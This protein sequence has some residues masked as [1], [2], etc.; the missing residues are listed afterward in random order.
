MFFLILN[1]I[2]AR[3]RSNFYLYADYICVIEV[4]N[5]AFVSNDIKMYA[6]Q[7]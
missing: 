2:S 7:D 6:V 4:F 3:H 5:S 1:F